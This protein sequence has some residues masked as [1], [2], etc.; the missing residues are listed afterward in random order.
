MNKVPT[1]RGHPIKRLFAVIGDCFKKLVLMPLKTAL[2]TATITL[3]LSV[4]LSV[5]YASGVISFSPMAI[6]SALM[7]VL[8]PVI[9]L[10][11]SAV[12]IIVWF[13]RFAA[14]QSSITALCFLS[15]AVAWSVSVLYEI[16]KILVQL[17][18]KWRTSN[19]Q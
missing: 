9:S 16:T 8:D 1:T 3:V 17:I 10:V 2:I 13:I 14:S 6:I 11:T 5:L 4:I 19:V 7:L 12:P 15:G 18:S